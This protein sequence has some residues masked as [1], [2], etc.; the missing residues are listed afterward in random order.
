MS[1]E[2]VCQ[3]FTDCGVAEVA[4]F[5]TAIEFK[6]LRRYVDRKVRG[7]LFRSIDGD[8]QVEGAPCE[9]GDP[10]AE[11]LLQ[12][13]TSYLSD[14]LRLHLVPTY[15]YLRLYRPGDRLPAHRDRLACEITVSASLAAD[16]MWPLQ[17]LVGNGIVEFCPA[18]GG[19]VVFRGHELLHWREP[20]SGSKPIAQVFFHYVQR[21]GCYTSWAND[22]RAGT[23]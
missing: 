16:P 20:L 14:L 23:C 19:A 9:Y 15:S 6:N 7:R 17:I 2:E 12:A 21:Y 3:A 8:I 13:K 10:V 18:P 4:E 5:F 11:Q 1:P 22:R